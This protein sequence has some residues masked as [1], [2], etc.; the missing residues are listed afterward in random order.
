MANKSENNGR[1]T[2]KNFIYTFLS[3]LKKFFL[4]YWPL[5]I[6][7]FIPPNGGIKR[8]L[9]KTTGIILLWVIEAIKRTYDSGKKVKKE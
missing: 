1:E 8:I 3:S 5:F 2:K 7:V 6:I 4:R 9:V